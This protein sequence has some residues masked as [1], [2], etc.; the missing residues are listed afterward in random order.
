MTLSEKEIDKSQLSEKEYQKMLEVQAYQNVSGSRTLID[1]SFCRLQITALTEIFA[2][3]QIVDNLSMFSKLF[4]F[5]QV[6][7]LDFLFCQ[8]PVDA[9]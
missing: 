6:D 5:N 1:R 3:K 9:D 4:G 7:D 8:R 2:C